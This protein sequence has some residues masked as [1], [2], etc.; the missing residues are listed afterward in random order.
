MGH[1]VLLPALACQHRAEMPVVM[2]DVCCGVQSVQCAVYTDLPRLG[3][4]LAC[5]PCHDSLSPGVGGEAGL[6]ALGG[7][8]GPV[9]LPWRLVWRLCAA[10]AGAGTRGRSWAWPGGHQTPAG[11][12]IITRQLTSG[13]TGHWPGTS[14]T[15]L[16]PVR[17]GDMARRYPSSS[18]DS[19]YS[20]GYM[21]VNSSS[22]LAG[23]RRE[24]VS[25][26]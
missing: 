9:S 15:T 3:R 26:R 5:Q 14:V 6:R 17:L 23:D 20:R 24:G 1:S 19:R 21:S 25:Y 7:G 12:A 18:Y 11:P 13:I 8:R 16:R 10:E 4:G 22:Y 2:C